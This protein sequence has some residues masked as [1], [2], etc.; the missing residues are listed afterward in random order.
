MSDPVTN[1]EVEDVLSSIRRLVSEDKRPLQAPRSPQNAERLVLTPALRVAEEAAQTETADSAQDAMAEPEP[2]EPPAAPRVVPSIDSLITDDAP[3]DVY[4]DMIPQRE[5]DIQEASEPL[6]DDTEVPEAQSV[7]VL[8]DVDTEDA[9]EDVA[10]GFDEDDDTFLLKSVPDDAGED[11]SQQTE[12]SPRIISDEWEE[13]DDLSDEMRLSLKEAMERDDAREAGKQTAAPAPLPPSLT[14]MPDISDPPET[15]EDDI[16]QVLA[17]APQPDAKPDKSAALS[18]KI[19]ALETAIGKIAETWEPDDPGD[20]DYAGAE[21]E[22]MEWEDDLEAETSSSDEDIGP[23]VSFA[24]NPHPI[25]QEDEDHSDTAP[26]VQEAATPTASAPDVL[27][28]PLE[29]IMSAPDPEEDTHPTEESAEPPIAA[30]PSEPAAPA[31]ASEIDLGGEEQLID[32]DALRDLVSEI[33]RAELQGAL[34]ERI[35]RNVRKLVRREIHRALT[36]Q[37]LE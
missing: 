31:T 16:D 2:Q 7:G 28:A 33:V 24:H 37:D 19:A 6:A 22:A 35:T 8:D 13:E 4:G 15:A 17:E 5:E 1:K 9:F 21:P 10:E 30:A 25:L 32:E 12:S 36:A 11:T 14:A 26:E 27:S 23:E 3:L 34:G 18:T 29:E 20:S